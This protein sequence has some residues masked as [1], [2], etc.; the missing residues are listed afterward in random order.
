MAEL[1]PRE[2]LQPCLLDRLTD[3]NPESVSESRDQRII[4]MRRYRG[5]VLRDLDW[6][7]NTG[8]H[9]S[10]E[11][12]SEFPE[13]ERSVLNF[14]IPDLCGATVSGLKP[15]EFERQLLQA[16][17]TFEPRILPSSLS[18]Q[19]NAGYGLAEHN[20]LSFEIHGDLWALPTPDPLYVRTEVDLETG[21]CEV[22]GR[23]NG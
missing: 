21:Q 2:R 17:R 8:A 11:D 3:D 14:G 22:K 15:E 4:S 5:A 18:I 13:A 12:L 7:L 9:A 16:I 20:S 19:V 10:S 23:P 6:L 1:T